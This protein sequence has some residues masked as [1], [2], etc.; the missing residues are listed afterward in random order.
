MSSQPI[1][2]A[3]P[4]NQ[5]LLPQSEGSGEGR[6]KEEE[7]GRRQLTK[8]GQQ[9]VSRTIHCSRSLQ[10]CNRHR[11]R[12][13]SLPGS[14]TATWRAGTTLLQQCRR[15]LR[16]RLPAPPPPPPPPQKPPHKPKHKASVSGA[17]G[18]AV[19]GRL[20]ACWCAAAPRPSHLGRAGTSMRLGWA[21]PASE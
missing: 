19:G 17:R 14:G 10:R 11:K 13:C 7:E 8:N 3:E 2:E 16:S 21:C 12:L 18:A 1:D 6:E 4:I 15:I 20:C 5:M 9:R